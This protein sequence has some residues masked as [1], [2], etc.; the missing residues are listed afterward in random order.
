MYDSDTY[1]DELPYWVRVSGRPHLV[2]PYNTDSNDGKFFNPAG[3]SS[4]KD[5]ADY[6]TDSFVVLY[7]EGKTKPRMIS[8]GMHCRNSGRPGRAMALAR[9][10]DYV[11]KHK[12]VWVCR[13]ED[14]ARHWI[15]HHPL[16][17]C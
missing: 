13:R 1:N 3:Y 12:L 9:F 4:G 5:F 6:L 8:V 15:R 10:L 16:E 11:G 14:L 17:Q 2:I 7:R